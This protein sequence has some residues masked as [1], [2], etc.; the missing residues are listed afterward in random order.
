[1]TRENRSVWPPPVQTA[2]VRRPTRRHTYRVLTA[3]PTET[4]RRAS[5]EL[6]DPNLLGGPEHR[7]LQRQLPERAAWSVVWLAVLTGGVDAWGFWWWSTS[8]AAIAPLIILAGVAGMAACWIV[9]DVRLRAFQGSGLVA[10]LIT[11]L[12][13]QAAIIN[14]RS[15]YSTDSAAFMQVAAR[16]LLHGIDPYAISMTSGARVLLKVPVHFW[17]DTVNGGHVSHF[18]YPAGS[19]LLEIPGMVLGFRHMV[20]DWTDL[21]CW[22]VTIV[23][24]FILLPA[25]LRWMAALIGLIPALVGSFS[26]GGTDALFLPFLVLAVWRWDRFGLGRQAGLARWIGPVGLGV[27]CAVKQEP[28]FCLPFLLL[29][30]SLEARRTGRRPVALV[31]RYL[32]TVI[33][34]F[35][36]IN[37]P[38]FVWQPSSWVRGTFLP[39]TGGLVADGQGIVTLATHGVVGGVHL[40][41]LSAAAAVG[42]VTCLMAFGLWYSAL[43]R[44]WLVLA[45]V[46]FFL[47]PRSLS[48]YLIDL[49]PA[50]VIAALSVGDAPDMASSRRSSHLR[51]HGSL[52]RPLFLI[53]PS[54]VTVSLCAVAF[55]SPPLALSIRRIVTVDS[56]QSVREV[57]VLVHNNTSRTITPHYI[58]NTGDTAVGFWASSTPT[59]G[60][61][62]ISR[63]GPDRTVSVA[64]YP[65]TFTPAPQKGAGWLVE[66]YTT[67]S[68]LSTSPLTPYPLPAPQATH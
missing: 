67:P 22:L 48:S 61:S 34:V 14:T 42:L 11:V 18:S 41:V 55:S 44:V 16:S 6:R 68:S 13:P 60:V 9:K 15:S 36:A 3:Q 31:M 12:F 38:F 58:V 27:A 45:I 59:P 24:M 52:L 39:F 46:P 7:H 53:V 35:A 64:L 47:S 29:G 30:V 5:D 4:Q 17:T 40:S 37:L 49:F 10:V 33:A 54:L 57:D 65:P 25:Q 1:M 51:R 21:I 28:W 8:A 20:V 63:I 56:G 2:V 26:S 32:G 23:L 19:F 62:G 43:K 50:I 66:A